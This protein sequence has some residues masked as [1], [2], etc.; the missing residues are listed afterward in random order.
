MASLQNMLLLIASLG[1]QDALR[2]SHALVKFGKLLKPLTYK[3]QP[4]CGLLCD[5][6]IFE[7]D[8]N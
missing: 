7:W 2:W 6:V 3:L 1:G 8:H 5:S 4:I